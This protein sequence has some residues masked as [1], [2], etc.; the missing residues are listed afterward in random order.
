MWKIATKRVGPV[1]GVVVTVVAMVGLV[2]LRP[3]LAENVP[4]A[5]RIV[6]DPEREEESAPVNLVQKGQ[7]SPE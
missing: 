5:G 7:P 4:G 2:F 6:G 1:G 3:W